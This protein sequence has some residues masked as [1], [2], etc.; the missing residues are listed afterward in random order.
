MVNKTQLIREIKNGY[1]IELD[2]LKLKEMSISQL[3]EMKQDIENS[4]THKYYK[5]EAILK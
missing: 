4:F 2:T 1:P 5:G 3:E